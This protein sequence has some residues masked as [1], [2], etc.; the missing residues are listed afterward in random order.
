[1]TIFSSAE[2]GEGGLAGTNSKMSK[3]G[4]A[5]KAELK[6]SSQTLND[7]WGLPNISLEMKAQT[8]VVSAELTG[9]LWPL[10]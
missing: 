10:S 8:P 6:R 7:L 4:G 5:K 1:M 9:T 2:K 3:E